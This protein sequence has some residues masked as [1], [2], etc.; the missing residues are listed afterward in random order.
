MAAKQLLFD[1]A[2]RQAILRGVSKLS[3]AVTATLGP[4]GRKRV[5]PEL[6]EPDVKFQEAGIAYR[7]DA[8]RAFSLGVDQSGVEQHFQML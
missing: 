7:I 8:P 4:K 2:A 5:V 1:E 3:R 6:I